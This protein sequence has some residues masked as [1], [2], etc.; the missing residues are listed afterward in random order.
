M[1]WQ[2]VISDQTLA[3][4]LVV[5]FF[6]KWLQVL[7]E[8]LL[9]S[10]NFAAVSQWYMQWK[11]QIPGSIADMPLIRD[12][13]NKGLEMMDFAVSSPFGMVA[14]SFNPSQPIAPQVAASAEQMRFMSGLLAA[15]STQ[16][17]ENMNFKQMLSRKAEECGLLFMP[18]NN[19]YQ[20]GKQVYTLGPHKV[21][22]DRSVI[23]VYNPS[24][25]C[26][27][28]TSLQSLLQT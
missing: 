25:N 26:W 19:K 16:S 2:G 28:P 17:S 20:D 18:I 27:T 23:F 9:Y 21:Y 5:H 4:I 11:S 3:Q 6:P 8:W 7:Y 12:Y 22:L 14:Y 1:S 24:S 13:L 15:A 10:P